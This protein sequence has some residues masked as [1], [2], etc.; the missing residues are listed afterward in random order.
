[1]CVCVWGG[2]KGGAVI[3]DALTVALTKKNDAKSW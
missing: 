2:G 1:M 3:I